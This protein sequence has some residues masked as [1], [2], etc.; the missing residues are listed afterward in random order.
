MSER[1]RLVAGRYRLGDRLGS[2]AMGVVWQAHDERLHRTIAV[3]QLLLQPGLSPTQSEQAR[4]RALREGRIAARLQ[5]GSAVT[6]HDVVTDDGDPWLIMEYL[7][8]VSLASAI[9]ERGT[10]PPLEVAGIG[11]Q[12]AAA[13]AAAHAAGIVHRDIKPGNV[14]LGDDGIAKIT[15]FGISR[16]NGDVTV[17]ATGV[18]SGTPAYLAPELAKGEQPSS[19][20]D[21][22]SLGSTLYTAVE[23]D[24]PF[25]RDDNPLALLHAVAAGRPR[26]P[27]QAGALTA[28]L[29]SMLRTEPTE[30]PTMAK[31]KEA[32]AA[33]AAERRVP[34]ALLNVPAPGGSGE[35]TKPSAPPVTR[36][37]REP[38]AQAPHAPV[39]PGSGVPA[40]SGPSIPPGSRVSVPPGVQPARTKP[41]PTRQE[42]L[43]RLAAPDTSDRRPRTSALAGPRG[44]TGRLAP[45]WD[46]RRVLLTALAIVVAAAL[47][48]AVASLFL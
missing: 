7:P 17:T 5:H 36:P 20:S 1:G 40:R 46:L 44:A 27:Q 47:G 29:M 15:D 16:A 21:V 41:E 4:Q 43:R 39:A 2:G 6:V 23:G 32:L 35:T 13:L 26:P 28:V 12:A 42:E 37:G 10:L 31:V 25:G 33:V 45:A 38:E 34:A 30:R 3:K 48:I 14:L 24:P 19:A 8:S 22:F 18:L 9:A 11:A